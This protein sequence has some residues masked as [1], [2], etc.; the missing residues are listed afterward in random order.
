MAAILSYY[1]RSLIHDY[2]FYWHYIS[3]ILAT[4]QTELVAYF[5]LEMLPICCDIILTAMFYNTHLV[6]Q[7]QIS[8]E[9]VNC[10]PWPKYV[11]FENHCQTIRFINFCQSISCMSEGPGHAV[12]WLAKSISR[13]TMGG[14]FVGHQTVCSSTVLQPR[15]LNGST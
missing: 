10:W 15:I 12:N 5:P 4:T 13:G 2:L 14:K 1:W 8:A 3:P 7:W 9:Y 11:S 6:A